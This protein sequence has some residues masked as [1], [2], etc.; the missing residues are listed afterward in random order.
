MSIADLKECNGVIGRNGSGQA[1]FD[2][3]DAAKNN[4]CVAAIE[5]LTVTNASL[6]ELRE[7]YRRL[8]KAYTPL[9]LLMERARDIPLE[10]VWPG[11]VPSSTSVSPSKKELQELVMDAVEKAMSG[12]K[13]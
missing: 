11:R 4:Q 7:E 1:T 9:N 10:S 2:I 6:Q 3:A 12:R 13:S 8:K 5:R